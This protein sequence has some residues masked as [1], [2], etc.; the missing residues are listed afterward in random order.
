MG[1][2][3]ASSSGACRLDAQVIGVE[4]RRLCVMTAHRIRA[5]LLASATTAF[6]QP[7]RSRSATTQV[8]ILSCRRCAVMTADFAPWI[9]QGT[10]VGVASLGDAAPGC[11][12]L[13]SSAAGASDRSRRR[14]ARRS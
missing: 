9:K 5:F 14:T 12:C 1:S 8:E 4:Q 3:D 10:Q 13:R 7:E 2:V 11:S 6:C